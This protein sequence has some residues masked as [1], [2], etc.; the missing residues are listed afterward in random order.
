[1]SDTSTYKNDLDQDDG[2]PHNDLNSL[3]IEGAVEDLK[4]TIDP[5][6]AVIVI[7]NIIS[8]RFLAGETL[9]TQFTTTPVEFLFSE[10][11]TVWLNGLRMHDHVRFV[12]R[13]AMSILDPSRVI[14]VPEH[15]E[16]K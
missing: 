16:F 4:S 6:G 12:G 8:R 3:L 7:C 2:S 14:A 11:H 13:L 10:K 1:M 9:V 15:I 5:D